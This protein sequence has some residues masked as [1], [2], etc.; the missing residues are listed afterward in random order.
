LREDG[1]SG[2]ISFDG[3]PGEPGIWNLNVEADNDMSCQFVWQVIGSDDVCP[4]FDESWIFS[5]LQCGGGF[6]VESVDIIPNV[7]SISSSSVD[8]DSS[9]SSEPSLESSSEP[10]LESSSEPSLESSSGDS[11]G[12][13]SAPSSEESSQE[14]SG[15]RSYKYVLCS[16]GSS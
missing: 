13:S 2:E 14:S 3:V 5:D 15:V 16:E 1:A 4:P 7:C 9:E 6:E 11:L 8:S 12:A 10:S